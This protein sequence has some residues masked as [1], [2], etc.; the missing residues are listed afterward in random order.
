MSASEHKGE[1][2]NATTYAIYVRV[3]LRKIRYEA[4]RSQLVRCLPSGQAPQLNSP[5]ATP[6]PLL[7][8]FL[9]PRDDQSGMK[10][11]LVWSLIA[12]QSL[13]L[14]GP[15]KVETRGWPLECKK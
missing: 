1:V 2:R 13:A 11:D 7:T 8:A 14:E 12:C 3:L 4:S 10:K 9:A 5:S 15:S 6:S